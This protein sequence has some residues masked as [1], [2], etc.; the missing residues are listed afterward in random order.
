MGSSQARWIATASWPPSFRPSRSSSP[1]SRPVSAPTC[2]L[3]TPSPCT[4]PSGTHPTRFHLLS[5][6]VLFTCCFTFS[7]AEARAL[8]VCLSSFCLSFCLSFC[9]SINTAL[10]MSGSQPCNTLFSA[11]LIGLHPYLCRMCVV[12]CYISQSVC[13]CLSAVRLPNF[14]VFLFM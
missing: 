8:S 9:Q 4:T 6:A 13:A 11:A 12:V 5:L 2:A 14:V 1:A 3:L 10:K 7:L